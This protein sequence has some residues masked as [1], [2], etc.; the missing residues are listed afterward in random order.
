MPDC[1]C[2]A[3]EKAGLSD[4]CVNYSNSLIP[5]LFEEF[6]LAKTAYSF[7]TS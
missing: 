2:L 7:H 3:T 4:T 6:H 5:I 1:N